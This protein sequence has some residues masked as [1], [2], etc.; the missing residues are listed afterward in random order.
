MRFRRNSYAVSTDLENMFHQ[1]AVPD[2]QQLYL[3]CFWVENNDTNAPVIE[4]MSSGNLM[5]H[6]SLL[7]VANLAVR[8]AVQDFHPTSS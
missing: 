8:Y 1:I 3:R 5:G 2:S 4:Y 6:T 7:A